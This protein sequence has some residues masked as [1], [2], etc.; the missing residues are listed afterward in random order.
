[1]SVLTKQQMCDLLNKSIRDSSA[2]KDRYYDVGMS[3]FRDN[4]YKAFIPKVIKDLEQIRSAICDTQTFSNLKSL[5]QVLQTDLQPISGYM[6]LLMWADDSILMAPLLAYEME[7]NKTVCQRLLELKT[8]L[9]TAYSIQYS[10]RSQQASQT[11]E[12]IKVVQ[13]LLD[14]LCTKQ[15]SSS[16]CEKF[17]ELVQKCIVYEIDTLD[18]GVTFKKVYE[19]YEKVCFNDIRTKIYNAETRLIQKNLQGQMRSQTDVQLLSTS[20]EDAIFNCDVTSVSIQNLQKNP[21]ILG[22]RQTFERILPYPPSYV[23]RTCEDI[24]KV[25]FDTI[26]SSNTEPYAKRCFTLATVLN[27]ASQLHKL[28]TLD[29]IQIIK[30]L[31]SAYFVYAQ[32]QGKDAPKA[33]FELCGQMLTKFKKINKPTFVWSASITPQ[34][35]ILLTPITDSNVLSKAPQIINA[36]SKYPQFY[37]KT[38]FTKAELDAFVKSIGSALNIPISASTPLV[39]DQPLVS[40]YNPSQATESRLIIPQVFTDTDTS[41]FAETPTVINDED[42]ASSTSKPWYTTTLGIVG[43]CVG[44]VAVG[45]GVYFIQHK[46]SERL[47]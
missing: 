1:M 37:T 26:P 10:T 41:T 19:E 8:R 40:S 33:V 13:G 11:Q 31:V 27:R 17:F 28:E 2:I 47:K 36:V 22:F 38:S 21:T 4:P 39:S 20:I 32:T 14:I 25:I 30:L 16:D 7:V 44:V 12:Q 45:G 3:K 23:Y 6:K 24:A 18:A 34:T 5:I 42:I 46:K 35:H 9:Q 29:L 43:I 15:P